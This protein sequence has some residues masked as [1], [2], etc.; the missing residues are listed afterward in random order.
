MNSPNAH[1]HFHTEQILCCIQV[2]FPHSFYQG[3][4]NH[5]GVQS[6]IISG[7]G[8][9]CRIQKHIEGYRELNGTS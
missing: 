4:R 2:A 1:T 3:Y 8:E 7:S 5:C 6:S 9:F